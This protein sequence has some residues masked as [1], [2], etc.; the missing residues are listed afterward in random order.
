LPRS[1][2]EKAEGLTARSVPRSQRP[3]GDGRRAV[4]SGRRR[5]IE[6]ASHFN[7]ALMC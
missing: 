5:C 7:L 3:D 6:V 2:N 4:D 1:S